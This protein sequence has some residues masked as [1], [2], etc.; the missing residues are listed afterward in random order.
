M[1]YTLPEAPSTCP[2]KD[3]KSKTGRV[4]VQRLGAAGM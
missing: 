4:D 1:V 3:S 2:A